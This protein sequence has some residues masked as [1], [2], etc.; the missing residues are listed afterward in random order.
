MLS[1]YFKSEKC[2]L[3]ISNPRIIKA[4]ASRKHKQALQHAGPGTTSTSW[5]VSSREGLTMPPTWM[6]PTQSPGPPFKGQQNAS[7]PS[8][9]QAWQQFHPPPQLSGLPEAPGCSVCQSVRVVK[10]E[11]GLRGACGHPSPILAQES[12]GAPL[13][14]LPKR[15]ITAAEKVDIQIKHSPSPPGFAPYQAAL[16]FPIKTQG[17]RRW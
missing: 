9:G 13:Y 2:S 5:E 14:P 7:V 8:S 11:D 10:G 15:R 1:F 4:T 6:F 16:C 12:Q 17:T 3:S